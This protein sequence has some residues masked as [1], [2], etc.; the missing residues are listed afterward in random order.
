M[1]ALRTYVMAIL[2]IKPGGIA[3]SV[4]T[5]GVIV[6][7][8]LVAMRLL[9]PPRTPWKGLT[10]FG[11]TVVIIAGILFYTFVVS[12]ILHITPSEW[13]EGWA[14][15]RCMNAMEYADEHNIPYETDAPWHQLPAF[16]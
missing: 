9:T 1:T 7:C 2:G 13:A 10:G 15:G 4:I 3:I 12:P 11:K 6:F 5:I 16:R 8:A 14:A